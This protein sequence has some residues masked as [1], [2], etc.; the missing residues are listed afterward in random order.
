MHETFDKLFDIENNNQNSLYFV[1]LGKLQEKQRKQQRE[2][3][4]VLSAALRH[5]LYYSQGHA[6]VHRNKVTNDAVA[7]LP[8]LP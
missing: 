5:C 4:H 3:G 8:R 1:K 6:P 7:K 2:L